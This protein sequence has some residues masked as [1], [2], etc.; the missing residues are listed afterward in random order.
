MRSSGDKVYNGGAML[1]MI[2]VYTMGGYLP[3]TELGHFA[4]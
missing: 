1:W 3:A 2:G 4:V